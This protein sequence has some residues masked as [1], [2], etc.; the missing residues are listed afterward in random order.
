MKSARKTIK[1]KTLGACERAAQKHIEKMKAKGWQLQ[2]QF[3][4][5]NSYL[6]NEMILYFF[7][8]D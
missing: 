3:F 1:R 6:T 4:F 2:E 7:K 8:G 5:G